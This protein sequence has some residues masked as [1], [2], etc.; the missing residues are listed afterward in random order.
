MKK[1]KLKTRRDYIN[2]LI[3]NPQTNKILLSP[4]VNTYIE[5]QENL[6]NVFLENNSFFF[7]NFYFLYKCNSI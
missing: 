3:D 4:S 6:S 5:T 7:L 2:E 1:K